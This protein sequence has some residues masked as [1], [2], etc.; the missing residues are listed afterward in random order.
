RTPVNER[1]DNAIDSDLDVAKKC[2][3]NFYRQYYRLTTSLINPTL[4][5]H[6]SFCCSTPS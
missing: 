3:Q 5:P 6:S 4:I 1:L 2:I